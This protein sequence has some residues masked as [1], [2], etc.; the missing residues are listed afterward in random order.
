MKNVLF[1]CGKN[2]RRSPTAE[3]I[4]AEN[5]QLEVASAGISADADNPLTPDLIEWANVIFVM[6]K[7]HQQKMAAR[8]RTSLKHARVICLGIPDKYGFMDPE[9]VR[10]LKSKVT[11]Y[12]R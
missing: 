8:F 7:A 5:P 10:I 3:Q 9:L 11:A 12:L 1:V 6:E 4:F 2:R